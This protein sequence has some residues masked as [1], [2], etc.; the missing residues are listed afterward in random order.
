MTALAEELVAA[1]LSWQCNYTRGDRSWS[2]KQLHNL[3]QFLVD[4]RDEIVVCCSTCKHHVALECTY[5]NYTSEYTK[6]GLREGARF[7]GG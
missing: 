4:H 6:C 7:V 3:Y 2:L 1:R 5:N